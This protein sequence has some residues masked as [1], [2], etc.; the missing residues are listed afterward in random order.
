MKIIAVAFLLFVGIAACNFR[1]D[2]KQLSSIMKLPNFRIISIDSCTCVSAQ[3]L[4]LGRYKVFIYFDPDCE[5]CQKETKA[6]LSSI[7][8]L[9]KVNIYWV[10]NGD[11]K[12]LKTFCK[13]F[14]LDSFEN[15]MV[16]EDY[17][18]SFYKAY[19]PPSVPFMAIYNSKNKLVKIY[20]GEVSVRSIIEYTR[21]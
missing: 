16:G 1:T 10:T 13:H 3:N 9:K 20:R 12:E 7:T 2:R 15:I 5:H 19:L 18:Y 11:Q 21:N 6:V 8:E 4:P 14:R 17:E